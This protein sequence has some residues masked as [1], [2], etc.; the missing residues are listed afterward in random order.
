VPVHGKDL[1]DMG[2][3]CKDMKSPK[4]VMVDFKSS[5]LRT[6]QVKWH[7]LQAHLE[8]LLYHLVSILSCGQ[9]LETL[10][11]LDPHP[12]F[13]GNSPTSSDE[14]IPSGGRTEEN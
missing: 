11:P 12:G 1:E 6:S 7:Q 4:V 8:C 5:S 2:H 13:Q 10:R 9:H 3:H 14:I